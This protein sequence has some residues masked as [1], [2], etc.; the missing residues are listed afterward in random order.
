MFLISPSTVTR[1]AALEFREVPRK[2]LGLVPLWPRG[3]GGWRLKLRLIVEKEPLRY[4]VA[5]VPFVLI[6]V[7]WHESA[8]AIAQAPA[9]M[10][11]VVYVVEMRLLRPSA[12]ARDAMMTEAERDRALDLLA[13]RGR[14]ILTRIA[15]G[16]R[17]A[18]GSLHLVVEHSELARVAPLA[19]VS[20][21][22]SEGP[23]ILDLTE[24]ERGLIRE[25]LFA[26]P[27]SEAEMLRLSLA[28]KET[29]HVVSLE[30]RAI[31]AHAR[32]AALTGMA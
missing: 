22:W 21:Q 28:R 8:L 14:Q 29:L 9:L 5:L 11:A 2:F 19:L 6:A 31:P 17:M 25:T 18:A 20:V 7:L 32:M 13:V 4:V 12:K 1:P 26:D 16:R 27:L 23:V 15:A 3:E 30:V 10:V 24:A